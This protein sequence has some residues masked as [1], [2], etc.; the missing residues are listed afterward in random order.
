D[1]AEKMVV[2][3]KERFKDDFYLEIQNHYLEED[4]IVNKKLKEFATKYDI[5]LVATND[6]H[7]IYKEDA[8]T[9]DV[10]MCVQMRKTL[11]DPDRLKLP[12]DQMYFKTR[13]EM[14]KVFPN[15][16]EALD[17]TLEIADK[18]NFSFVFGKYM[19]SRYHPDNGQ[20]PEPFF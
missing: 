11:D 9:Q 12:G 17:T 2:W 15:D 8:E 3:F 6:V 19:Y 7:Y 5:K 20:E 16:F 14:E 13:E 18:C 1:E 4:A 10:L